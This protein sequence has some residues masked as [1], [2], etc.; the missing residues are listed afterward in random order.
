VSDLGPAELASLPKVELHVHLEG[1]IRAETAVRLAEGHGERPD[2]VLVLEGAGYPAPFRDF[3]HFVSTFVATSRQVRTPDDLRQ[4]AAAFAREQARQGVLY[5]EATFTAYTLAAH[6]WEPAAMWQAITEGLAEVPETD[7]RLIVDVPRDAGV[8]AAER[9]IELVEAADAPI[10][11]LGLSG[12]ESSV[13]EREFRSLREA[14]HRLGLGLA[15][16]AGETGTPGNVR[17]A[18]DDLG[19]DR[20]GHGIAAVRD[21]ALLSRLAAEQVPLE[22]CPSS[23]VALGIVT[24]LDAH[25]LPRLARAGVNVLIGSDDPPFFGTT[26]TEELVH[27]A[28]LLELDR[29]GLAALQQRAVRAAFATDAHRER[30]AAAIDAWLAS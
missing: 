5:T 23:N 15:V 25:P 8:P 14:A 11:G 22:V 20:I 12:I 19:A 21:E 17:A 27:A 16:H 7:V 13:P 24:G 9:T 26:L 3:E 29:T 6:G 28:R 4:V 1:S 10:C 2:Q 18:L 30:L